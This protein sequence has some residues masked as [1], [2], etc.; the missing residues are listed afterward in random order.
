[1]IFTDEQESAL[2]QM[3]SFI[4]E[5]NPL[6]RYRCV[7]GLAGVGKSVILAEL[8][9]RHPEA[10]LCAPFGRTA[11]MLTKRTGIFAMTLHSA[12]YRF[13]G[14]YEDDQ[15]ELCVGFKSKI[16]QNAWKKQ[17]VLLDESGVVG[18]RLANDLLNTGC[19]VVATGDGGQLPPVRDER[20]F[21]SADTTLHKV[22][23]QAWDSAI[24][25]QAHNMRH[26]GQ[27]IA[28]GDDFRVQQFVG[29]DDILAA[30]IIICWKNVTRKALNTL[31][32]AHLGFS[33]YPPLKGEQIMCLNNSNEFNIMN[34]G[35]YTLLSD[36]KL[37][38]PIIHIENDF[39]DEIYIDGT[40]FED[41]YGYPQD[42]DLVGF[43]YA[44]ASTAHKLIGSECERTIIVDEYDAPSWRREWMYTATTRASKAVLVQRST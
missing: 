15:G 41:L 39:G 22:Q 16:P 28:D 34:G 1:M 23:R 27:Y 43:A 9:H 14:E 17:L 26:T 8:A 20:F 37:R 32:R 38:N 25:R 7:M 4:A 2:A 36:V 33:D 44:Y 21:T 18:R 19:K 10:M 35:I 13:T 31:K 5:P 24:I 42:R 11:S 29:R 12:I 3:E 30:N 6:K 40:W